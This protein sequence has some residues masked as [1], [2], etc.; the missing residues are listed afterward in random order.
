ML[1][2]NIS[3]IP[4]F[5]LAGL[6]D[7]VAADGVDLGVGLVAAAAASRFFLGRD[8]TA[9]IPT[10]RNRVGALDRLVHGLRTAPSGLNSSESH[11][12][13]PAQSC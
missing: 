13:C 5:F 3:V 6:V 11:P 1:W 9:T 7:G 2:G 4:T 8:R 10:V 12:F